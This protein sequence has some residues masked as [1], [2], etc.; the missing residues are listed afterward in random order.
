M[1]VLTAYTINEI[2]GGGMRN[3]CV[4]V[5]KHLEDFKSTLIIPNEKYNL[6]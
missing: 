5:Q 3:V 2:S 6:K 4:C 1:Y